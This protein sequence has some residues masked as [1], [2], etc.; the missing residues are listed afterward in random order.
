MQYE[1]KIKKPQSDDWGILF[2]E[3]IELTKASPIVIV[4]DEIS[5]IRSKDP[6]FL[7][8]LKNAWDL[9]FSKNDQ[10]IL[11]LCGSVS[12]WIEHNILS[13]TGF[14]GRITLSIHLKE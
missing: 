11:I 5:W 4:L 8:K 1:L 6:D 7:G 10:L 12:S 9:G 13:S 2:R 14:V 3:L